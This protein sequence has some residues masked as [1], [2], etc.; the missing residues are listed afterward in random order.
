M[1]LLFIDDKHFENAY[2][3]IA[4]QIKIHAKSLC[5]FKV[6][7]YKDDKKLIEKFAPDLIF[8]LYSLKS[9]IHRQ[10]V[11]N[12]YKNKFRTATWLLEDK[13]IETT[14]VGYFY[15][16]VF[17]TDLKNLEERRNKY[18]YTNIYFLSADEIYNRIKR[19]IFIYTYTNKDRRVI[20]KKELYG[21]DTYYDQTI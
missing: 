12:L 16:F 1:K 11:I 19:I 3:D 9:D 10:Q 17:T 14:D 2:K 13:I 18:R 6:L 4:E 15:D 20:H 21:K 5:D 8:Y 7:E